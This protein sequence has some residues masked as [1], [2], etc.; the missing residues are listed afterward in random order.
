MFNYA[1]GLLRLYTMR[2][3]PTLHLLGDKYKAAKYIRFA[4]R[5]LAELKHFMK[6][7]NMDMQN[8]LYRFTTDSIE[9]YV[10]SF[11]GIDKIRIRAA[12]EE[13]I[14]CPD[15]SGTP[16]T[17]GVEELIAFTKA[18]SNWQLW[19]F[20]DGSFRHF[21]TILSVAVPQAYQ[22]T[23]I[24]TVKRSV[25]ENSIWNNINSSVLKNIRKLTKVTDLHIDEADA[26]AE[27]LTLSWT[28]ASTSDLRAFHFLQVTG[29]SY[30]YTSRKF[31]TDIDL[32]AYDDSKKIYLAVHI[33]QPD[34]VVRGSG[35]ESSLGGSLEATDMSIASSYFHNLIELTPY[36][37]TYLTDVEIRDNSGFPRF[38]DLIN[39]EGW[40]AAPRFADPGILIYQ[41][42]GVTCTTTKTN[43]ITVT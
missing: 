39:G 6:M 36:V 28:T 22:N 23:G 2:M 9:V 37:G 29:G 7:M 24:Y 8:R 18:G 27:Y 13:V 12:K 35:I 20:G 38:T 11:R 25:S 32:T 14:E 19:D 42:Q 41:K 33:T 10:E 5:K 17:V 34:N 16:T 4:E 43:Y 15:F 3:K 31:L 30:F 21:D 40:D 26:W 1:R